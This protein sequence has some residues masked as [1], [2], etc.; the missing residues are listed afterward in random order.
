MAPFSVVLAS[1]KAFQWQ[2]P[3]YKKCDQRCIR[4]RAGEHLILQSLYTFEKVRELDQLQKKGSSSEFQRKLDQNPAIREYCKLYEIRGSQCFKKYKETAK[5]ELKAL[6]KAITENKLE[7]S[8]LS[9]NRIPGLVPGHYKGRKTVPIVKAKKHSNPNNEEVIPVAPEVPTLE[10]LQ[11]SYGAF[12][13]KKVADEE[14][15]D[16]L[17]SEQFNDWVESE[18]VRPS[19]EDYIEFV[20]IPRDP[21]DPSRGSIEVPKRDAGGNL[22]ISQAYEKALREYEK[23][24][25]SSSQKSK[26]LHQA[27]SVGYAEKLSKEEIGES[28]IKSFKKARLP[29]VKRA[30]EVIQKSGAPQFVSQEVYYPQQLSSGRRI[31]QEDQSQP[32][33]VRPVPDYAQKEEEEP[34]RTSSYSVTIKPEHIDAFIEILEE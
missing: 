25:D 5:I 29:I 8:K 18:P 1:Q 13:K 33:V 11:L 15:L 26:P 28:T 20:K 27:R 32:R 14:H 4:Q 7:L 31:A 12:L 19:P 9:D 16:D 2:G 21:Q 10:D 30:N 6:R 3:E 23:L 34:S 17:I 22:V 24:Q